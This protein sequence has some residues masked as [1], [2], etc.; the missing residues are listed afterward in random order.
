VP[1]T[2]KRL[3]CGQKLG[4]GYFNAKLP[5]VRRRLD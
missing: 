4:D 1:E 2:G 3:K 5:I